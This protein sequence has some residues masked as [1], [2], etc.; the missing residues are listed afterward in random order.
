MKRVLMVGVGGMGSHH[1]ECWRKMPDVEVAGI[2]D[3]Y[4]G[5]AQE[6]AKNGEAVFT[7]MDTALDTLED[8][9]FVDIA[10]PS[11]LHRELSVNRLPAAFT[12]SAKSRSHCHK[13]T[14][15]RFSIRQESTA[16]AS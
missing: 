2:C 9:D 4:P 15:K 13:R 8:L 6:K 3:V 11:Y 5:R 1:L 14:E 7:D 12:P 10:V 16:P